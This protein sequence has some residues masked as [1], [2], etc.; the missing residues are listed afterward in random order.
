MKKRRI[1]ILF[2][3][4]ALAAGFFLYGRLRSAREPEFVLS[5][6]ENQTEDYPTT[7]GAKKFAELVEKESNGRIK[8]LVQ[9]EGELGAESDVIAQMQYG[10][11]DF[12]RVSLSQL[13][14]YI[15]ELNVLQMP[16]LYSD[17]DHMWK[18]LDGRSGSDFLEKVSK[19][20]LIGLSWY[21]AGARNF[22]NSQKPIT[23]L[24]DM[25][26]MR[27]R[28][29]ESEVMVDMVEAL[30]ATALPIPYADV[31]SALERGI[32]DGAENN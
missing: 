11:I 27:I 16:Y 8:I 12:A 6:A 10:G 23:C 7:L 4:G 15:P 1:L 21:D 2:A 18:V 14:E 30:G 31:Y 3:A 9:A 13:A 17:S 22:Y 32:V 5:Y 26:G 25:A 20:E 19:S 24:E 28:V 29:Q